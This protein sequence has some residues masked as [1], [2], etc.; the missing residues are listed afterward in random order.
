MMDLVVLG[1]LSIILVYNFYIFM[2][3]DNLEE[4]ADRLV[5]ALKR[6]A[7]NKQGG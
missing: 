3:V 7:K 6:I 2:K 5:K 4:R 1:M